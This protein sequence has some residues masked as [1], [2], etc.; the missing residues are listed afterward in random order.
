MTISAEEER[1]K[2]VEFLNIKMVVGLQGKRLMVRR[3]LTAMSNI[4]RLDMGLTALEVLERY[5]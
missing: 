5:P 2:G 4:L 1:A 3:M